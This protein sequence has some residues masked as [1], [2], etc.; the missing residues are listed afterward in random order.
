MPSLAAQIT[1]TGIT[2][3]T[4]AE[5]LALLQASFQAIYGSDAYIASDSQDGQ[6]IALF[7]SAINDANQA[8][9]AA[10]NNQSPNSAQAWVCPPWSSSMGSGERLPHSRPQSGP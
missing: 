4:Y 8:A 3:P 7:A 10:Y 1:P 9:I 5:I 2:A 6:L